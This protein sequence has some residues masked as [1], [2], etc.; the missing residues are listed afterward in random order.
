MQRQLVVEE[1]SFFVV[2]EGFDDYEAVS[3]FLH[4]SVGEAR[5]AQPFDAS[6][7][8]VGEVVSVVYYP[9]RVG[10]GVPDAQPGLVYLPGFA[11]LRRFNGP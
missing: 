9:L 7:L 10:L 4:L 11:P 3:S 6:D 2:D 8:E 1:G 5:G